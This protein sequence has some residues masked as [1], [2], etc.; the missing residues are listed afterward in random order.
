MKLLTEITGGTKICAVIGHPVKHSLSP[1][2]HNAAFAATGLDYAYVAFDVADV[3]SFMAGIRACENVVGLSVTIPHK[4]AVMSLVDEVDDQ[5]RLAGCVNTVTCRENRLFGSLT[6]GAGV[7]R[8]FEAHGVDLT[9]KRVLFFGSGGAVRAVA[10]ALVTRA[11]PAALTIAGRTRERVDRLIEDIAKVTTIPART[12]MLPEDLN[13]VVP[14][15][16][17]L[18]HG[19]PVG[20]YGNH[21]EESV[22][23]WDLLQPGQVVLDMVYRP[24]WTRLLRDALALE[25]VVIPGLE[26]LLYQAA[27]QFETWTGIPAPID[28]MRA[29]LEHKLEQ[30]QC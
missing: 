8:A 30:D 12:A 1:P 5:A 23:P 18:I 17:I 25:C 19:T 2:M 28:V 29:V 9:G 15:H 14:E 10:F 24:R 27:L 20:M 16:D 11:Q 13:R 3:T 7:L 4:I 6:D 22:V 26:M 21:P